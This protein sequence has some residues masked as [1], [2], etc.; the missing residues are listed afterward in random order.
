L[1]E[2]REELLR[3]LLAHAAR[4]DHDDV[5]VAIVFRGLVAGLLQEPGHAF[6]V[7][8]VHLATECFDQVLSGHLLAFVSVGPSGRGSRG[9]LKVLGG[10]SWFQKVPGSGFLGSWFLGSLVLGSWFLVLGS[11]FLGSRVLAPGSKSP[12]PLA[13]LEPSRTP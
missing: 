8:E 13:P 1:A 5:R 4:V 3:C 6:R 2:P 10:S 7:V 11:R 9:F 12:N